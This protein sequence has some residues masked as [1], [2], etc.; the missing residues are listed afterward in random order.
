VLNCIGAA[1]G[2]HCTS[3]G[4]WKTQPAMASNAVRPETVAVD[5]RTTRW[6]G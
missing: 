1:P 3:R 2:D 5:L 4:W 6:T